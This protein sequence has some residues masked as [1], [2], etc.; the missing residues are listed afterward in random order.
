MFSMLSA[1]KGF[2]INCRVAV[3][4]CHD[5]HET[6][7]EFRNSKRTENKHSMQ[8][9]YTDVIMTTMASQITSLTIVYSTVC[10][11]AD[12]RKHQIS[13]SLAFVRGMHQWPLNSPHKGSVTRKMLPF[14]DLQF[15]FI[16]SLI[17]YMSSY[18]RFIAMLAI[19]GTTI[20]AS[21]L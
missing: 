21:Y 12:Q 7:M 15:P 16:T 18:L 20:L 17:F 3:D 14:D 5:L 8:V 9:H 11:C 13:A 6:S 4:L 10:S 19:I 2:W 1:W